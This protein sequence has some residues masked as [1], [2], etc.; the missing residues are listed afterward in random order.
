MKKS[1]ILIKNASIVN[2]NSI[3][4]A[5]ILCEG[6]KILLID[7]NINV[8]DAKIID[9]TDKYAI[10][11]GIDTHVHFS[12]PT[13][14]GLT[15]DDFLTGSR[16]ALWGGTTTV[17]DF[18]TPLKNQSLIDAYKQRREEAS[19]ALVNVFLHVSPIEWTDKTAQEMNILV[20]EY[21]VKSF[22]VYMAYKNSIGIDD[23][24]LIR[25][26]ETVGKLKAI[27]IV[28]CEND[29]IIEYLREQFYNSG[30]V[31]PQY[32]ALSRPRYSEAEAVNRLALYASV[33]NVPV[34]VV[35]VSTQ[36]AINLIKE[37]QR[38][39]IKFYAETCPQYLTFTEEMYNRPFEEAAK[40]VM[41]P[42]L[43]KEE[44]RLALW[45]AIIDNTVSTIGTDHC[46]FTNEQKLLGRED[47]RR[48]PNG[49]G[50]VEH[51]L[52]VLYTLG[53][54]SGKISMQDFVRLTS[55]N[56]SVLFGLKGKGMVKQGY[57]ADIVIWNPKQERIISVEN[58][59][60]NSDNN[61][62][63]GMQVVGQPEIVIL[64]GKIVK[65]QGQFFI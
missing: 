9:A 10:P 44:D 39:G 48:I 58:H 61:I 21:G 47:F 16:A 63:E 56:A 26:L 31:S 13:F 43:R 23:N 14:A 62:Y 18:V 12:L 25:V 35:H 37:K 3:I 20:K 28:H 5:D 60:M 59:K 19:D 11:G 53:V 41:S 52:E 4:K 6:K 57:D 24:T 7:K 40:Y 51:R 15:P 27:T 55:Y 33:L 1:K 8:S 2:Y 29:E 32:H 65:A 17:I 36:A 38:Q 34:Y 50:G 45:D 49:A 30:R 64:G 46:S 22:K 42:P 54:N